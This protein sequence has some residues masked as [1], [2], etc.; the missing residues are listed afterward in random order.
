MQRQKKCILLQGL[1]GSLA[2]E[3]FIFTLEAYKSSGKRLQFNPAYCF[4]DEGDG[5]S[6]SRRTKE[7]FTAQ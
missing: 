7:N 5:G 1:Q 4:S 6:V 2:A 3:V